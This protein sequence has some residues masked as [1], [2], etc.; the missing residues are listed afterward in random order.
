MNKK[1]LVSLVKKEAKKVKKEFTDKEKGRLDINFLCSGL[2]RRCFYGQPTGSCY[3]Y[4]ATELIKKCCETIYQTNT[5]FA[6]AKPNGKPLFKT[7]KER[8]LL[9]YFSPIE[10]FISFPGNKGEG[11][12]AA[13]LSFV[14]GETKTL[15]FKP[16]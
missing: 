2:T 15:K 7:P 3:S 16:F 5:L 9:N 10:I 1:I 8:R 11:N 13:L 14:K 4:R 12:N 6:L